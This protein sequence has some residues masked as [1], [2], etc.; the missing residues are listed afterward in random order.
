LTLF[1]RTKSLH[2]RFF[3]QTEV[4]YARKSPYK[5]E[6]KERKEKRGGQQYK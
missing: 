1:V 3:G 2:T 4:G 5:I 6:L